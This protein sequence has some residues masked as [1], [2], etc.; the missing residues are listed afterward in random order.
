MGCTVSRV[1]S[2]D[3]TIMVHRCDRITI[4]RWVVVNV[5]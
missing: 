5:Y 2:Y 3:D 4:V 1:L